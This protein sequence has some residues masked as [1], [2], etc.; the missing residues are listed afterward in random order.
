MLSCPCRFSFVTESFPQTAR[1]EAHR[2]ASSVR[3]D[4][5]SSEAARDE[6]SATVETLQAERTGLLN[7]QRKLVREVQ[8]CKFVASL[9]WGTGSGSL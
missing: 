8:L 4:L 9:V 3:D 1:D 2:A 5:G 6:L 7:V